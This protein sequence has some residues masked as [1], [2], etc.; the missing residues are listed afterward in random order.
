MAA[1]FPAT[2]S[3]TSNTTPITTNAEDAVD[4]TGLLSNTT[5]YPL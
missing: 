1:A 2:S 4:T 3:S 5:T